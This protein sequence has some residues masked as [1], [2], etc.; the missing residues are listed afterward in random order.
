MGFLK[1]NIPLDQI[2][3]IMPSEYP[4]SSVRLALAWNGLM[5]RYRTDRNLSVSPRNEVHFIKVIEEAI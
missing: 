1:G 3:D 2:Y 5:I 4:T